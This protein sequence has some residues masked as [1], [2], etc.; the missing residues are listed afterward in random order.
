TFTGSIA[1]RQRLARAGEVLDIPGQRGTGRTRRPAEN[2]GC[3]HRDE[4]HAV[5]GSIPSL[6]GALHFGHWWQ[7]V[8]NERI[9]TGTD[10]VPP[11]F[12]RGCGKR[13]KPRQ[14]EILGYPLTR[15]G[16]SGNFLRHH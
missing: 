5:V 13:E 4:E 10:D 6:T 11:I 7:S 14:L 3:S 15:R 9:P 12:G 1:G 8:H 2:T 16:I